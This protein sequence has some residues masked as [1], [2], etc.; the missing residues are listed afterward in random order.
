MRR[1]FGKNL[2]LAALGF[3]AVVCALARLPSFQ[4]AYAE[5]RQRIADEEWLRT[6]C[7]DP[8]FIARL[9]H[10]PDVCDRARASFQQSPLLVGLQ[11]MLPATELP[12]VGWEA[13][14]IM[15]LL[16][17][18][19]PSVLL[20]YFRAY[21]DR[22]DRDRMLEACSPDLPPYWRVVT[23]RRGVPLRCIEDAQ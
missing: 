22:K 14:A 3:A 7:D 2:P 23:R 12:H 6:Q 5:H 20:P 19:A 11:A 21:C 16:L 15:A 13:M 1:L 10:H 9:R 8:Q 18:A 17:L 4:R